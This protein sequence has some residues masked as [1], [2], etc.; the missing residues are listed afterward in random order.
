MPNSFFFFFSFPNGRGA[1]SRQINFW[2]KVRL[3]HFPFYFFN[4]KKE[5]GPVFCFSFF[6][7]SATQEVDCLCGIGGFNRQ[8]PAQQSQLSF[9]SE[10][11][12]ATRQLDRSPLFIFSA[13]GVV[14]VTE[15]NR[16]GGLQ[17]DHFRLLYPS[18]YTQPFLVR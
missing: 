1:S 17:L 14:S 13:F 10:A 9:V 3:R 11:F 5:S 7:M 2:P 18:T 12:L 8:G 15:I 4:C 16:S 6:I